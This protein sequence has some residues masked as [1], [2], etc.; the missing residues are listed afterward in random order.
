[1]K[2]Q[3]TRRPRLAVDR[4]MRPKMPSRGSPELPNGD[5]NQPLGPPKPSQDSPGGTLCQSFRIF[6]NLRS[7]GHDFGSP[8]VDFGTP[9]ASILHVLFS[10]PQAIKFLEICSIIPQ[11]LPSY[12][13]G[14]SWYSNKL[15][16]TPRKNFLGI[17]L[18][19]IPWSAFVFH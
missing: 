17:L 15:L 16:A 13:T 5:Q 8:G 10:T 9:K 18:F 3:K 14:A 1:M 2:T 11:K 19:I 12:H 7:P 4:Q 6:T